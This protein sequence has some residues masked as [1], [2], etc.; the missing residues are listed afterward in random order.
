MD[1]DGLSPDLGASF[2]EVRGLAAGFREELSEATRAMREMD[3]ETRALARSLGSSLRSALDRA[4]FGGG[5]FSDVF[6][7]LARDLAGRALDSALKPVQSAIG[8][9][10]ASL[11][12]GVTEALTGALFAKGGAFSSGQVR[13]FAQGGVVSGPTVFPMRRGMG[14]MGE[15]GP[16]AILP[17]TRGADGRLGVTAAGGAGPQVVVN[18]QTPDLEGFRRSRGQV[19]ADLARAVGRGAGRL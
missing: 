14:L 3:G 6:K 16:E 15:A 8:G 1:D 18:I 10:I 9:G 7:G 11:A 17:L 13:A 19:A 2:S 4:I 12:G 5:K